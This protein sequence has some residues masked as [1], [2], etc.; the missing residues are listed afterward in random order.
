MYDR[1]LRE[2]DKT[3]QRADLL[4]FTKYVLDDQAHAIY[5]LWW[6][7]VVPHRAYV[8]GWKIGPSHYVNQDLGT[9]WLDQ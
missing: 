4:E 3:K 5:L 8:K 2:L 9:V 1:Q 7:R 6:Q